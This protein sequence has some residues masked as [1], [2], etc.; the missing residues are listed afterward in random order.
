MLVRP[1][2]NQGQLSEIKDSLREELATRFQE[3]PQVLEYL[4][5]KFVGTKNTHHFTDDKIYCFG[6]LHRSGIT[7]E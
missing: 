1:V 4:D 6:Q 2:I 5:L 7:E 3:L